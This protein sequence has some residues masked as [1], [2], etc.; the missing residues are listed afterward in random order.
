M[1][2]I[3]FNSIATS[4]SSALGKAQEIP[5]LIATI[6]KSF[7]NRQENPINVHILI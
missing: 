2:L 1:P 5:H 6:Q 4:L 7:A 3:Q